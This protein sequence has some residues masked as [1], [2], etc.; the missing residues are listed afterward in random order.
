[1]LMAEPMSEI[2][3]IGAGGHAAELNDYLRVSELKFGVKEYSLLG[4]IDDSP[5][6]FARYRLSAPLLGN[7]FDHKVRTDCMYLLGIGDIEVRKPI[8]DRFLNE[9][10]RFASFIHP[11]SSI[12]ES[13]RVGTGVVVAPYANL[14]PNVQIGD[15]TLVN[16]RSSVAHDSVVGRYNILCP[17]V[18][19]SAFTEVGDENLFGINSATIPDIHVGNRN[20]IAAGMILD[21]DVSDDSV[22]F[23]RFRE[24]VIA[25]PK[26]RADTQ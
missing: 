13:A 25:I 1:M 21:K 4:F 26:K 14:G 20:R 23:H 9:G 10:A 19:F 22:V 17:N 12:S 16:A 5:A 15:F 2:I 24:K 7:L 18:C 8:V 6:N 3:I 11:S